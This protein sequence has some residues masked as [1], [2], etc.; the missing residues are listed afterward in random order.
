MFL[1]LCIIHPSFI[2][3]SV[4]PFFPLD[5]CAEKKVVLLQTRARAE[6]AWLAPL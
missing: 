6:P 1:S 4:R 2:H 5:N 3:P